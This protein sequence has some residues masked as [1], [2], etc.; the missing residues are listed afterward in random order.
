MNGNRQTYGCYQIYYLSALLLKA[1]RSIK[2]QTHFFII[3]YDWL[4]RVYLRGVN[5]RSGS[6]MIWGAEDKSKMN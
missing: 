2:I 6:L 5:W 3:M 4:L 1:M